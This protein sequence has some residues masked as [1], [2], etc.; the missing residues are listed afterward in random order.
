MS[1]QTEKESSLTRLYRERIGQPTTGDEATGYWIFALGVLFGVLGII[2]FLPSTSAGALRQV[3]IVLAAGG[4][5]L[6]FA[7]PLIRLPLQRLATTLVYGG[8]LIC[9]VGILYFL[10]IYPAGWNPASGQP[11]VIG[12]YALGLLVMGIGGVLVPVLTTGVEQEARLAEQESRLGAQESELAELRETLADTAADEDDLSRRIR[13][14]TAQVEESESGRLTAERDHDER[15]DELAELREA[16]DA[17]TTDRH[18]RERLVRRLTE[19]V[20]DAEADLLDA[21][22]DEA[23]LAAQLQA[24]RTSQARF[25]LYR[26]RADEWRWRLR[27]RNGNA[28]ADSGEGYTRRHDAQRGL[29]SVRR[30]ALGAE[31][32]LI[33]DAEELPDEEEAFEPPAERESRATFETYQD[34]GGEHRWRLRHE[35]GNIL[36][37]S[38]EGYS[39]TGGRDTAVGR[40]REYV[41]EADYLRL[42]P[43]G[44][45]VYRDAAGEYRWRLVHENGN[46]LA[47]GSE[48]YTR[49]HDA[50]RAVDRMRE[51][52]DDLEFEIF[53]DKAGEH[54]WRALGGNDQ[55]VADSGEGYA[56][57]SGVEEAV[58]RVQKHAPAADV[59]DA[60]R[61]AFE[62]FEDKGGEWR[63]RLRHRNGNIIADCGEGYSDRS[64]VYE[65]IESMKRNAPNADSEAA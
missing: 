40:V 47:D 25:E 2:L 21:E 60:G 12:V 41:P 55:I 52:T 38:G 6:I 58:E 10:V 49:R 4:L 61:A 42:D 28:I 53:E 29:Q 20:E 36:A 45:E 17:A 51:R 11:L 24:L 9:A 15:G 34:K 54:R 1:T 57:K 22:A 16:L 33:E 43:A 31:L 32:R 23:D 39:S 27:H 56:S 3:A 14:L 62:I 18:E 35:N 48:G 13:E 5:A 59:L 63:W 46:I 30:N 50:R 65:A 44:F 26:D 8:L 7:G 64:G 37:D 19:Q